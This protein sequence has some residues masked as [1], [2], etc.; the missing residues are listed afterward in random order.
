MVVPA[1]KN[2][3]KKDRRGVHPRVPAYVAEYFCAMKDRPNL[4]FICS[5]NRSRSPTAEKIFA[6]DARF[7]A[8]SAGTEKNAAVQVDEDLLEW[9]DWVVVMEPAHRRQLRQLFPKILP[10]KK[11]AC[12]GI[13]DEFHFMENALVGLLRERM[14]GVYRA[15]TMGE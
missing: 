2:L 11:V 6:D 12:L 4:L 13:P 1:L 9:A 3:P 10:A 14:E 15:E 8:A 5:V 7:H